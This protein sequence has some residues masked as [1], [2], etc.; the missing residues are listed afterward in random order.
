MN[1]MIFL[2]R[3]GLIVAD[4]YATLAAEDGVMY[5]FG[6]GLSE[7]T[8]SAPQLPLTLGQK[9]LIAGTILD[10]SP[11]QKG[12]PCVSKESVAAQ[13]EQLHLGAPVGG[14]FSGV[15]MADGSY[16]DVMLVGVPVSLD[17]LDPN[18]NCYNIG[19]VTSDGYSGTFAFDG[20]TPSVAGLYTITAT[21]MG[22]ESYG[23]SFA[24]TYLT[25]T[26]GANTSTDNTVLYAVIGATV[27]I[28]VVVV[29]V[30]FLILRK[31]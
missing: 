17:V 18:G 19:V 25:V 28:I 7:T 26:E 22:D 15:M 1:G 10:L 31:K 4:G 6:Q 13:M 16:G 9:A 21:F 23:S 14:I 27:A 5:T 12:V 20:W 24:T 8:V 2:R 30:G 3:G 29:I 11:A